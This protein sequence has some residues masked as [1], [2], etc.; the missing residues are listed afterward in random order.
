MPEEV[1]PKIDSK[2]KNALIRKG[3][4]FF[5]SKKYDEAFKCYNTAGYAGGIEKIGDFY[6]YE[7]RQPLVALRYY[8]KVKNERVDAKINEIYERMIFAFK[9]LLRSDDTPKK[10]NKEKSPA[11]TNEALNKKMSKAHFYYRGK[12]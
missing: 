10:E 6:F 2:T 12:R 5:N 4:E 8:F 11:K 1:S 9:K 3:N 7:G